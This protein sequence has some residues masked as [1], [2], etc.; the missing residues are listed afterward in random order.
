[1][2]DLRTPRALAPGRRAGIYATNYADT[3]SVLEAG[4]HIANREIRLG[5]RRAT[6]LI[7]QLDV[8]D[9]AEE[10]AGREAAGAPSHPEPAD[11]VEHRVALLRQTHARVDQVIAE[12]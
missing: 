7:H 9:R 5:L 1:M 8:T 11:P 4:R 10:Q 2:A 6:G 3:W 12:T